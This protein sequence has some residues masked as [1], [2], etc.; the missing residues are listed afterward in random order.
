VSDGQVFVGVVT[1]GQ[2]RVFCEAFGLAALAADATLATQR[3]RVE[4]RDR[5]LPI[6][7]AAFCRFTRAGLMA[8]CEAL[9]LPFAPISRPAEMFDDP[10]LNGSGGLIAV[11]L[12]DGRETRLPALPLSLDGE[13]LGR[14]RDLPRVGEH[15]A[16]IAL[17][18]GYSEA[19][20][21]AMRTAGTLV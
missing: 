16:E 9:G 8:R 2:W 5:T 1:D 17:E 13:R 11:T 19:E 4:A 14:R 21:A 3:Q 7:A 20:I 6:V 12:P 18:L 15:G 10:H